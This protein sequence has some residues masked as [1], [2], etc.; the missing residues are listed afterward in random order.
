L[1]TSAEQ[2]PESGNNNNNNGFN[3]N[4]GNLRAAKKRL[5][6]QFTQSNGKRMKRICNNWDCASRES[7]SEK[8]W[9]WP[10]RSQD[11]G[12]W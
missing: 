5:C 9:L 6:N 2:S 11:S 4:G 1:S 10:S 12:F 8:R 3:V 7:C